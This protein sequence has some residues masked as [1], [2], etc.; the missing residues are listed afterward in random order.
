MTIFNLNTLLKDSIISQQHSAIVEWCIPENL[1]DVYSNR[2][3]VSRSVINLVSNAMAATD[4]GNVRIEAVHDSDWIRI[5]VTD[6]GSGI[7]PTQTNHIMQPF[8]QIKSNPD[9]LGLG[10]T[11]AC[12]HIRLQGSTLEIRSVEGKGVTACFDVPIFIKP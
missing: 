9:Q 11:V 7:C 10:L 1:P 4:T 2:H 8:Y 5:S 6:T 12:E 3:Y